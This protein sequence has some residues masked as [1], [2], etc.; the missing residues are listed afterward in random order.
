MMYFTILYPATVTKLQSLCT[1]LHRRR[2]TYRKSGK[3]RI[4]QNND[5]RKRKKTQI[6]FFFGANSF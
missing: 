2:E 6:K 5:D 4:G 1:S 3:K